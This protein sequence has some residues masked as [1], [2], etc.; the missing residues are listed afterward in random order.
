MKILTRKTILLAIMAVFCLQAS[1]QTEFIDKYAKNDKAKVIT[2]GKEMLALLG[3]DLPSVGDMDI[4][5]MG[6]LVKKVD[7]IK[8]ATINDPKTIGKL[9]KDVSK[10]VKKYNYSPVLTGKDD[11]IDI[12]IY[13][14]QRDG[15]SNLLIT[16]NEG[17]ELNLIIMEGTFTMADLRNLTE[18]ASGDD[19]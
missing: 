7:K 5:D 11:D 9:M 2:I 19:E 12:G 16:G 17:K 8:L 6:E 1:A 13:F 10:T 3:G 4:D 14:L 15:K 18:M